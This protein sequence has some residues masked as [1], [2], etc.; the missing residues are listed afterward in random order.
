MAANVA[1]ELFSL[2][3]LFYEDLI[4]Y[5]TPFNLKVISWCLVLS[6]LYKILLLGF[7]YIHGIIIKRK[8]TIFCKILKQIQLKLTHF[9]A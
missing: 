6:R 2:I 4:K 9:Q 3:L 7:F 8:I 1:F 5:L